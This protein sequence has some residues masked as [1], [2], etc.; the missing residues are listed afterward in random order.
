MLDG[1][2]VYYVMSGDPEVGDPDEMLT[3]RLVTDW[4]MTESGV[5]QF[6]DLLRG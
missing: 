2:A 1:G 3:G 6:L 5:S 4:S